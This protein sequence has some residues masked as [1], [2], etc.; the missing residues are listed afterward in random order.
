MA[1]VQNPTESN[2]HKYLLTSIILNSS[3]N[4]YNLLIAICLRFGAFI[5]HVIVNQNVAIFAA[6]REKKFTEVL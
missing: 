5:K 2:P 3:V 1:N 6:L 4:N